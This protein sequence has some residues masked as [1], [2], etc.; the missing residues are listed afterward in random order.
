MRLFGTRMGVALA[1]VIAL[2]GATTTAASAAVAPSSP[3]VTPDTGVISC[4]SPLVW[5]KL[6]A[7][8]GET[9][10]S[11]NGLVFVNRSGVYQEQ[12]LGRHTVCL[13][14]PGVFGRCSTG[15]NPHPIR[16]F[17]PI[18]VTEITIRTP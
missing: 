5:L 7:N 6:W 1:A 18:N 12:I 3:R 15:P 13:Y 10:Y 11:G 4:L 16:I 9:C 14:G 17:P 8:L 2:S